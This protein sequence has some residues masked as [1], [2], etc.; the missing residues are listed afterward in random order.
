M[1]KIKSYS[2]FKVQM[3]KHI[4]VCCE[5]KGNSVT[6]HVLKGNGLVSKR[7]FLNN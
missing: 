6:D 5:S 3:I 2:Y 7:G 4:H 1:R